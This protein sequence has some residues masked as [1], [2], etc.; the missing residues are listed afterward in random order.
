MDSI[1]G[2][3]NLVK[4]EVVKNEA[5]KHKAVKDNKHLHILLVYLRVVIAYMLYAVSLGKYK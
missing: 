5:V 4:H 1:H 2:L 3:V